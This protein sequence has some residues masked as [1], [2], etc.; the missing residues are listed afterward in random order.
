MHQ[1]KVKH[2]R[3]TMDK[4]RL[5]ISLNVLEAVKEHFPDTKSFSRLFTNR[6]DEKTVLQKMI[7]IEYFCMP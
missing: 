4:K 3:I 1:K 7:V 2:T 5:R 6:A